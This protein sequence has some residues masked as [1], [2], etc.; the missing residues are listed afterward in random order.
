VAAQASHQA[1]VGELLETTQVWQPKGRAIVAY[2]EALKKP[3]HASLT[4]ARGLVQVADPTEADPDLGEIRQ[5]IDLLLARY[6]D[7]T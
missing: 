4:E 7:S 6:P 1:T 5:L 3:S 2:A